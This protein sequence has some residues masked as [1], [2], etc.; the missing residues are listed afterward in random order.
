MA[1]QK[2]L[3]LIVRQAPYGSSLARAAID[4]ALAAAAFDQP[5]SLL[6]M[7]EGI[8]QL[9]P[10]QDSSA[11][12]VKNLGKLLASLPLYDIDKVYVD[13]ES[14]QRLGVAQ[15]QLAMPAELLDDAGLRGLLDDNQHLVSC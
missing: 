15:S 11:L 4:A 7:G 9:L 8:L 14:M 6:F 13:A 2:K 1:E 12:G 3:L 10:D 5:V